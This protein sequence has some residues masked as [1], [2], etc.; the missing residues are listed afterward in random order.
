MTH[1]FDLQFVSKMLQ[2]LHETTVSWATVAQTNSLKIKREFHHYILNVGL[3][4]LHNIKNMKAEDLRATNVYFNDCVEIATILYERI[5]L[6]L[7]CVIDFDIQT[8]ALAAELLHNIL[9][10]IS[11]Q[12]KSRFNV[13]LCKLTIKDR[14]INLGELLEPL[15]EEYKKLIQMED[16]ENLNDD[17]DG[18]KIPVTLVNTFSFLVLNIPKDRPEAIKVSRINS[19]D[20]SII[21][22]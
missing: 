4:L 15:I 6:R 9:V 10:F 17:T 8:T 12:Y 7:D 21:V 19:K 22:I 1:L 14:D 16:N 3:S 11:T 20:C 5:I 13:F 18:R 2:M